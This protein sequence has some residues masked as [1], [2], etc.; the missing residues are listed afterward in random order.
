MSSCRKAFRSSSPANQQLLA[1]WRYLD[2]DEWGVIITKPELSV[3]P[4][5]AIFALGGEIFN[6]SIFNADASSTKH[7]NVAAIR[8]KFESLVNI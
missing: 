2:G 5:V 6:V 3:S 8:S 4:L 1:K 7:F